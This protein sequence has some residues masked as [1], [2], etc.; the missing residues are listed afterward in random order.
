MAAAVHVAPGF[1]LQPSAEQVP[2]STNYLTNFD[3][4]NHYLPD[5]YVTEFERYGNRTVASFL[6]LVG[7]EIPSTG[8]TMFIFA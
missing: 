1:A 4:L 2:F 7:S 8:P 5:T 3:F 6:P